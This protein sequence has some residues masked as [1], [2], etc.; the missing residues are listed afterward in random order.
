MTTV[1]D[2]SFLHNSQLAKNE[3][4]WGSVDKTKLPRTAFA[5]KGDTKKSSWGFPH[6]WVQG[7]KVG[8]AGIYTSGVM[9]LHKGGLKAAWAAANGARSGQEASPAVKAH[10]RTH[11]AAI[12]MG[13]KEVATLYGVSEPTLALM[14][15][16]L[17]RSGFL[18]REDLKP[19]PS[20]QL[21]EY[22]VRNCEDC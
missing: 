2:G 18:T 14:D 15:T 1:F 21:S 4:S 19:I 7:G 5:E 9:Y 20:D 16:E 12:G 11:M 3:P 22:L 13:N 17:I 8:D 6:H 10:L